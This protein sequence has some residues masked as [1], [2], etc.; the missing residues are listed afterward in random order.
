MGQSG[1]YV[2]WRFLLRAVSLEKGVWA[3]FESS[4]TSSDPTGAELPSVSATFLANTKLQMAPRMIISAL[5]DAPLR[6]FID[7]DD[8]PMDILKLLD[9]S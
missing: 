7:S 6:E 3:F 5:G 8:Y 4:F 9:A 2:L 1:D